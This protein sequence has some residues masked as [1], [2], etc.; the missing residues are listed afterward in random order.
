MMMKQIYRYVLSAFLFLLLTGPVACQSLPTPPDNL[1][2]N[3]LRDWLKSNWYDNHHNQM[4][5]NRAREAMYSYVDVSSDGRVYCVYTG[6]SQPAEVTT[7]LD[8][9]N[10][11]HT[12]PQSFFDRDEPMKSD[13]HHLFPTHGIVNSSRGNI[14]FGEIDDAV[15]DKW[16]IGGKVEDGTTLTILNS[17][18]TENIDAYTEI[19]N[20]DFIEVKEDNKGNTAR[21]IFYFYTVYPTQAGSIE[22]LA[23]L[24]TLYEWHVNDPVDAAE[25]T[26]ND[27]AA[28]RQGNRNPYID[29]P[30][31]AARAWEI[32]GVCLSPSQ[33]AAN[34][35]VANLTGE[36][37][38][39]SWTN[40]NGDG[41]VVLLKEGSEFTD[42]EH[43]N[44]EY[45]ADNTFGQG[46]AV[47]NAYIVYSGEGNRVEVSGLN[48]ETAYI[49]KIVEYACDPW[50]YESAGQPFSFTT[51]TTGV[52]ESLQE[53]GIQV[54]NSS[55]LGDLVVSWKGQPNFSYQVINTLGQVITQGRSSQRGIITL[56]ESF[57][58][59][60]ILHLS[61]GQGRWV[62][63]IWRP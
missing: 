7:F 34:P 1:Q 53:A 58:G 21:A 2:G 30:E 11:E 59:L 24:E 13:L 41:R 4:G 56:P 3:E 15:T 48:P 27:R 6:F 57:Q 42:A 8:P 29:H 47:G 33:S 46:D 45:A 25:M 43:P 5:Y 55:T 10:A 28:E 52:S 14:D 37:A 54:S 51:S 20:S 32:E 50:A 38:T 49:G 63:R 9:I 31:I 23:D 40:G 60:G 12:V 22:T 19:D 35:I 16:F 61:N 62:K 18:P 39:F 44:S 17:I 26:R 36:G